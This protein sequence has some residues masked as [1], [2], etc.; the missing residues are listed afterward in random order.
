MLRRPLRDDALD[1]LL[2]LA[3]REVRREARVVGQLGPA[4]RV[5]QPAEDAVLVRGD[6]HPQVVARPE[7]VRRSDA[8]QAGSR[9]LA[10]DAE[11]VVLRHGA[12]EQRERRLHQRDVDDL[13]SPLAEHVAVVERR[14]DALHG[15]HRGER[16]AE[17]DACARRRL[18]REAVDVPEAAHRLRDGGVARALG[19]RPGLAVP[20][21]ACEHDAG[22]RR[23]QPLVAEVPALERARA[24][25]L[26][27]DV[28]DADELEQELLAPR[29]AQVERDALLVPRL[30]GPPEGAALVASVAPV[31]QRVGLAGRLD[32]DH[33][34]AHVAEQPAGERA[35][36]Q[37]AE[38]D[39]AHARERA[40]PCRSVPD[41]RYHAVQPPSTSSTCPVTSAA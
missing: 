18:A 10:D 37:R 26:G 38:L 15:E 2:V 25:V 24:E 6:D 36:E 41:S 31:A 13:P 16:V 28:R 7:D 5:A 33:L 1:L 11:P 40:G 39:Q 8:L 23:R 3:P 9:R 12:L 27:D 21:D 29:L 20:G 30:Y 19:V 35:C 32:L 14:Q 4:H 17:R 22:V 34:G